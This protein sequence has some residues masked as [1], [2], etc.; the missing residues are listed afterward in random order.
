MTERRQ[1]QGDMRPFGIN[2]RKPQA[3]VRYKELAPLTDH[4]GLDAE[5]EVKLQRALREA[6]Q[7]YL[8]YAEVSARSASPAK[9]LARL[10][11]ITGS[12]ARLANYLEEINP[13]FLAEI[14]LHRAGPDDDGS[15]PIFDFIHLIP[16][17]R[18]L[19]AAAERAHATI[20][21]RPE[22]RQ[23]STTLD[24]A[25]E[26][27]LAALTAAGLDVTTSESGSA[28]KRKR[29]G[30]T[31]GALLMDLFKTFDR[32]IGESPLFGSI[33]RVK[34]RGSQTQVVRSS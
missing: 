2:K 11:S 9:S 21:R 5:T 29:V 23:P 15:V 1:I 17:L 7:E 19:S 10:T 8:G 33:Q 20:K 12:S 26:K 18:R 28:Q 27:I 31:G 3:N 34:A 14:D 32:H 22:G 25:V 13:D 30:G 4:L 24:V 16:R 6:L